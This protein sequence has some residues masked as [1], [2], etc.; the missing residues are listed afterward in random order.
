MSLGTLG[1][2]DGLARSKRGMAVAS[3]RAHARGMPP[4]RAVR[5]APPCFSPAKMRGQTQ[6]Q[7]RP[8]QSSRCLVW[9]PFEFA[10]KKDAAG[11][12]CDIRDGGTLGRIVQGAHVVLIVA[13]LVVSS[14]R[15][16]DSVSHGITLSPE[17]CVIVSG[18]T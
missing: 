7:Q 5:A 2:F 17:C 13:V 1:A 14:T 8:T 6:T 9:A 15:P 10:Y 11:V 12:S 18:Q 3:G 16:G 4:P